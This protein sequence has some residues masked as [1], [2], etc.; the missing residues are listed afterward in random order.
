MRPA[1]IGHELLDR[2]ESRQS[3]IRA[4]QRDPGRCG[5]GV[6]H[7]FS[8][9][10]SRQLHRPVMQ[11]RQGLRHFDRHRDDIQSG[12]DALRVRPLMA[13]NFRL[14]DEGVHNAA[15]MAFPRIRGAAQQRPA[16]AAQQTRVLQCSKCSDDRGGVAGDD[17]RAFPVQCARIAGLG[18]EGVSGHLVLFAT[19]DDE[20]D[21]PLSIDVNVQR[22][23]SLRRAV[24]HQI[25]HPEQIFQISHDFEA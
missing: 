14:G 18:D 3:G 1:E 21:A 8:G 10:R 24:N 12:V 17:S 9:G 2:I 15:E 22:R 7:L 13:G 11:M 20:L 16:R 4:Y 23:D 25:A 19:L 5:K 6:E